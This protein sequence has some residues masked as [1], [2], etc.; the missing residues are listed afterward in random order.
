MQTSLEPQRWACSRS[1]GGCVGV[2]HGQVPLSSPSAALSSL[3]ASH[4]GGGAL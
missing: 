1:G 2:G 3:G 4:R